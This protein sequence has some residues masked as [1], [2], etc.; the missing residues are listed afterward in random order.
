MIEKQR[1]EPSQK[2]SSSIKQLHNKVPIGKYTR[3]N[4]HK[5]SSPVIYSFNTQTTFCNFGTPENKHNKAHKSTKQVLLTLP[6]HKNI[7]QEPHCQ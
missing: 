7:L 5:L 3:P 1:N 6:L 4:L 2:N